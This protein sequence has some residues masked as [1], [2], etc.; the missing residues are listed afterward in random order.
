MSGLVRSD[1]VLDLFSAFELPDETIGPDEDNVGEFRGKPEEVRVER[2]SLPNCAV[3]PFAVV[4]CLMRM[5]IDRDAFR[6]HL[7][8]P[9]AD[10]VGLVEDQQL[11]AG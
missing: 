7:L 3:K 10:N 9:E 4:V 2:N 11:A 8:H 6:S 5:H 1:V